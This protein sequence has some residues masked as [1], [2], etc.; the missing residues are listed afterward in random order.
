M[1]FVI[2][3]TLTWRVWR[4]GRSLE[5]RRVSLWIAIFWMGD[6]RLGKNFPIRGCDCE[7]GKCRNDVAG[8]INKDRPRDAKRQKFRP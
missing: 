7:G 5:D 8:E 6:G 2:C 3:W 4:G 1:V